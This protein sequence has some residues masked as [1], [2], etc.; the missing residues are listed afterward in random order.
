MP[1][2]AACSSNIDSA[3]KCDLLLKEYPESIN[4]PAQTNSKIKLP[5]SIAAYYGKADLVAF[6]LQKGAKVIVGDN[7][8]GWGPL[9]AAAR[10]GHS[11]VIKVVL[12]YYPELIN[13]ILK[14]REEESLGTSL[15][16]ATY[17]GNYNAVVELVTRLPRLLLAR[18]SQNKTALDIA[19]LRNRLHFL[20]D[21][22]K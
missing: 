20:V 17:Y 6:L 18:N 22:R 2:H 7:K 1:I 4:T 10:A 16:C 12:K 5:V 21:D 3:A 11:D 19:I 15:H 8:R 9:Y 13:R 14:E